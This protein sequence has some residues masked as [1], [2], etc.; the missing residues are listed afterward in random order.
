MKYI[1]ILTFVF[2]GF[3]I[4]SEDFPIMLNLKSDVKIPSD[5]RDGVEEALTTLGYSLVDDNAQKEALK[6][7]AKARNS[8]CYDDECL[9]DT[10]KML[11]ARALISVKVDKKGDAAYKF[12]GKYIDF[13]TGTTTK[14]KVMYYEAKLDDYKALSKFGKDFTNLLLG[15]K[16]EFTTR[17][18]IKKPKEVKKEDYKPI[19][20][21]KENKVAKKKVEKESK[22]E[23]LLLKPERYDGNWDITLSLH[24]GVHEFYKEH[25]DALIE[26][27]ESRVFGSL[28]GGGFGF[29][30]NYRLNNWL[31]FYGD[32]NILVTRVGDVKT[33]VK[34]DDTEFDLRKLRINSFFISF[35]SQFSF[36]DTRGTGL[37]YYIKTAFS[38]GRDSYEHTLPEG[39]P[40]S[41][42]NADKEYWDKAKTTT[43]GLSVELGINILFNHSNGIDLYLLT[44]YGEQVSD[45]L[46]SEP[47]FLNLV[48]GHSVN[49]LLGVRYNVFT[50]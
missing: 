37:V 5:F 48:D 26:K 23:I 4:Y 24:G 17:K 13:E 21:K 11:A 12:K 33:K 1:L 31:G 27:V 8:E 49:V 43:I 28:G 7:N 50:F 39:A 22:K 6:E 34:D 29:G 36:G 38:F 44:F 32:T 45:D 46:N 9:V 35:G 41:E 18:E 30:L 25:N 14:T 3:N 19:P 2:L 47:Y 15:G 40:E 20:E 16:A 42:K 10:G